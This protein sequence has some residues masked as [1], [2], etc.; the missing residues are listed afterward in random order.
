VKPRKSVSTLG[1][2]LAFGVDQTAIF[3]ALVCSESRFMRPANVRSCTCSIEVARTIKVASPVT[4]LYAKWQVSFPRRTA[5]PQGGFNFAASPPPRVVHVPPANSPLQAGEALP[6]SVLSRPDVSGS[7]RAGAG[8]GAVEALLCDR[9]FC[10][11]RNC[12]RRA[13]APR[14]VSG[15]Y[16]KRCCIVTP[17]ALQGLKPTRPAGVCSAR[18]TV[19]RRRHQTE[20][21]RAK[22]VFR[23]QRESAG[24]PRRPEK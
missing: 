24:S 8:V 16:R 11:T 2:F 21:G 7:V 12:R 4:F 15:L 19:T 14:H 10:N 20:S 1:P 22:P 23:R 6:I 3:A 5:L 17:W 9:Q 18:Q 13:N